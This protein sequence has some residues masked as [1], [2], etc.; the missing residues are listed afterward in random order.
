MLVE[1]WGALAAGTFD[2]EAMSA[3]LI[4]GTRLA[5]WGSLIVY[6]ILA[7]PFYA[8][9]VKRRHD[10]NS[11]GLDVIAFIGLTVLVLVAQALGFG[12]MLVEVPFP[13]PGGPLVAVPMSTP[14]MVALNAALG[15]FSIYLIVVLGFL[16]GTAGPNSYGPD[17]LA[18]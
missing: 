17:P 1:T 18:G 6:L 2:R 14:A 16:R 9:M 4:E 8:L 5:A 12:I 3:R 7:F 11:P 13:P 15:V 10:R